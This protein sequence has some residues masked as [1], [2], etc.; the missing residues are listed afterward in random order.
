MGDKTILFWMRPSFTLVGPET[1]WS[2]SRM[3]SG[4]KNSGIWVHAAR[5]LGSNLGSFA[6]RPFAVWKNRAIV[7]FKQTIDGV[8]SNVYPEA[9]IFLTRYYIKKLIGL[10]YWQIY[11]NFKTITKPGTTK[12]TYSTRTSVVWNLITLTAGERSMQPNREKG[13]KELAY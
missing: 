10:S 12:C 6:I 9:L 2:I 13:L 7:C 8:R 3:K 5:L 11:Q 1:S 4:G